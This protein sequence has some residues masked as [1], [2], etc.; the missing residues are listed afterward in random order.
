MTFDQVFPIEQPTF[1]FVHTLA[2]RVND[3]STVTTDEEGHW[4]YAAETTVSFAGY[5]TA[6][7]P[8]EVERAAA[9][10]MTLDAVALCGHEV[11]IPH[12]AHLIAETGVPSWLIGTY[13]VMS[14]RPNPSHKRILLTRVLDETPLG[15]AADVHDAIVEPDTV[16]GGV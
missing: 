6:P 15:D 12:T 5:L 9:H 4:N 8:R 13:R 1:L 7:N 11:N 3:P 14:V 2:Y 16:E 10:G